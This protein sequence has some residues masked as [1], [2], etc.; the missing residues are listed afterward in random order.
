MKESH[1][2]ERGIVSERREFL[3]AAATSLLLLP[4]NSSSEGVGTMEPAQSPGPANTSSAL[5]I[6]K[7]AS[8]FLNALSAGRKA[9]AV[10][11][12]DDAQ[13][14]DWHYNTQEAKGITIQGNGPGRAASCRLSAG[15]GSRT[16]R[17]GQGPH[18][19]EP[20]RYP[21]GDGTRKRAA[22]PLIIAAT[23]TRNA[24]ISKLGSDLRPTGRAYSL[25]PAQKSAG[26]PM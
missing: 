25:W 23:A 12:F 16:T 8:T 5:L 24:I 15:R 10:L 26:L 19:H 21:R 14:L 4:V 6:S 22:V 11:S 17:T 1:I 9:K 2:H 7:T 18:H 20:G 3:A 13:R